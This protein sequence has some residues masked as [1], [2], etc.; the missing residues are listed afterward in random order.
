MKHSIAES[1]SLT[2]HSKKQLKSYL[3]Q[4]NQIGNDNDAADQISALEVYKWFVAKEKNIYAQIN[5]MKAGTSAYIGYFWSPDEEENRIREVLVNHPTTDFKKFTG[6][7]IK[8]PTYI[9]VNDFTFPF[10][11]IVN[12]YGM[13]MYKEINPAIF[14]QVSFPF[15]FGVMFGDMG[16]GTL[17]LIFGLILTFGNEKLKGTAIEPLLM[18]RYLIVMMGFFAIY[19]GFIYNEWFSM[20]IE[21][22][23][24]CYTQGIY[25]Y[26]S[27]DPFS[28]VGYHRLNEDCVYTAGFDPRW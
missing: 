17:L 13:P 20:P 19:N 1:K 8:P 3:L 10:Q 22:F 2:E 21:I 12:T 6:H 24:S 16:H 28:D 25:T 7:T 9:K 5:L 11:E 27:S 15:L 4:I 26:N 18:A 14:A 23:H